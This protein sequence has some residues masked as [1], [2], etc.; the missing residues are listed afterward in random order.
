[1]RGLPAPVER[2]AGRLPYGRGRFSRTEAHGRCQKPLAIAKGHADLSE[3]A[4]GQIRQNV[5]I[6]R[7]FAKG[8]LVLCEAFIEKPVPDVHRCLHTPL[9]DNCPAAARC[10]GKGIGAAG[11]VNGGANGGSCEP[12][13]FSRRPL[14]LASGP[15]M[16]PISKAPNGSKPEIR[17]R[18]IPEEW[19]RL[20]IAKTR[21]PKLQRARHSVTC[22]AT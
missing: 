12:R 7:V 9:K 22:K 15:F 19:R 8:F 2:P 5:P 3:V 4:V 13:A 17:I 21:A 6:D 14:S 1:M 10:K 18:S 11:R 16:G 20:D